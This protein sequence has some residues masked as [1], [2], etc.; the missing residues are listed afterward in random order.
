M[1]VK[2]AG[3]SL[4]PMLSLSLSLSP[5][6][7]VPSSAQLTS[8]GGEEGEKAGQEKAEHAD[9]NE[10]CRRGTINHFFLRLAT[11][12]FVLSVSLVRMRGEFD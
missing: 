4:L 12:S 8:D 10:K 6:H 7:A 5:S 11:I 3:V 9:N 1:C 2:A